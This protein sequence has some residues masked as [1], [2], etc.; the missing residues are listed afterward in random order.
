MTTRAPSYP[1]ADDDASGTAALLE[2][3]RLLKDA[4]PRRSI[5]FL[6]VS[7]EEEGL[8]GSEAFL[9]NPPI[10]VTAIKADL[11]MD[12][13][14]RGRP[15]ELHVMPARRDGQVTTLTAQARTL[16]AAGG[17]TLSAGIEAYWSDSDHYSFARRGIPA[18]CFNTGLHADYHQPT[19][20]PDKINYNR[21]ASVVRIVRDL[22]MLTARCRCSAGGDSGQRLAGLG[23]GPLRQPQPPPRTAPV[24]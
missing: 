20:T 12:M 18:I 16:A 17:I 1:G 19:D 22:A 3:M 10:A 23:V 9:A 21:L 15:G 13:V 4:N 5:A 14:G 7:G 6:G 11:N 8:L 2:V 24:R